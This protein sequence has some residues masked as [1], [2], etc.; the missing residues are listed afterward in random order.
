[1]REPN[2]RGPAIDLGE[3]ER[4]LRGP[5]RKAPV[6]A[7]PLSELARLMDGEQAADDPYGRILADP[8][9]TRAPESALR[10]SLDAPPLPPEPR[11]HAEMPRHHAEAPRVEPGY[12]PPSYPQEQAVYA[13]PADAAYPG[14][15]GNWSDDSQYLD[16]GEDEDGRYEEERRGFRRWFR[17][18]HA[19]AAISV[20]AVASIAW[21][22]L[23]RG[24]KDG[25][26]EIATITAPQG[27]VKVKPATEAEAGAPPVGETV[28]DRKDPPSVKEIVTNAEQAVDPTVAPKAVK[29]GAGPVDAPH[30]TPSLG[31]QPRRVKPVTVRPD[32][33]RIDD[34]S[35]PPA[36]ARAAN[37]PADAGV[38]LAKGVTPKPV[39]TKPATTPKVAKPKTPERIATTEPPP[40]SDDLGAPSGDS[41]AAPVAKG[42]Y[43][44]QFA[45]AAS[46]A[47]AKTLVKTVAAKYGAQFG[48]AKPSY[49]SAT[50]GDKT[51]YRVR[52]GGLSKESATT[53]CG[54]V[55]A[56]GGSCFVA[57]N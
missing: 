26:R 44:V 19:V 20:V 45:A 10:G 41:P 6:A 39:A 35:L 32:G 29:L 22:F 30:E 4:R 49:K 52:V 34:A 38:D 51:V 24:G 13:E 27:P 9:A 31:V 48:G 42:G 3:F 1:M 12:A 37:P 14:A 50:V 55:K 2:V 18:W 33:T 21:G 16:Y 53:I 17:P 46:E 15:E 7:D 47:E 57:A 54:K 5:E 8:R 23:H 25:G 28:L 36:L 56:G 43:A 11:L 40:A